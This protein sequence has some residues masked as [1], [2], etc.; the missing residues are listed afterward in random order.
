[1]WRPSTVAQFCAVPIR[2][3]SH[4]GNSYCAMLNVF[5]W[6]GGPRGEKK[7]CCEGSFSIVIDG[8]NSMVTQG[9]FNWAATAQVTPA[10]A[11]LTKAICFIEPGKRNFTSRLQK[12]AIVCSSKQKIFIH[13]YIVQFSPLK[14]SLLIF[15]TFQGNNFVAVCL[16]YFRLLLIAY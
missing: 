8:Y 12:F 9:I 6:E 13:I 10:R 2:L 7:S 5:L 3:E 4:V 14:N 15:L 11:A 1:M 16:R